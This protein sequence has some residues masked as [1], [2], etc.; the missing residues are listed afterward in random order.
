MLFAI[1]FQ[2]ACT[3]A[4]SETSASSEAPT[5]EQPVSKMLKRQKTKDIRNFP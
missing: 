5:T 3:K 2:F 4:P 1:L